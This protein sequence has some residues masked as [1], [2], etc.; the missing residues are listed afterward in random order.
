MNLSAISKLCTAIAVLIFANLA[1]T[2]NDTIKNN[3]R[4][5]M[6]LSGN[7]SLKSILALQGNI[8][9]V[10][11]DKEL[12]NAKYG[13]CVYSLT[14]KKSIYQKSSKSLLTPASN[15]KLF[16]SFAALNYLGEHFNLRSSAYCNRDAIKDG[17]L[18]GN[19]YIYGRGDI[20][21]STADIEDLAQQIKNYGIKKIKGHVCADESF[22]DKDYYRRSYSGD[23]EEVEPTG[24]IYPLTVEKNLIN[25]LVKASARTGVAAN[26][27]IIPSSSSFVVRNLTRVGNLGK[28]NP[29][30]ST[31]K[32]SIKTESNKTYITV[33]GVISPNKTGYY[34]YFNTLP[35]ITVA[36]VLKDRLGVVGVN[37]D[38][39]VSV[40]SYG[41]IHDE[42]AVE[43]ANIERP[44]TDI[45]YL[46]NKKSDNFLAEMMFKIVGGNY[47]KYPNTAQSAREKVK[48][49][50][51]ENSIEYKGF[52]LND[53][54]GLSR[55]NLVT[56][57][58]LLK[59]LITAKY[60]SY[61]S[62]LDSTLAIAG[63]DGTLRKRMIGTRAENNLRAKT[64]T[65]R[66]A[67]ALSGYV[68]AQS[69]ELLAFSFIF[70]GPS[71]GY[72]KQK[73]NMIGVLLAD[74]NYT[75]H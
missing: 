42:N 69:G 57:D 24:P 36:G 52:Q 39:T 50:L 55:R 47:G 40:A 23:N 74:F 32:V 10:L 43:V 58:A 64:G 34:S 1:V 19:I 54:C 46:V 27:Q 4:V 11:N 31:I 49:V 26:V 18:D 22:F 29:N 71:V 70:N 75:K 33:S 15:T 25:V 53:G 67:S 56:P 38:G 37:V 41:N 59:L 68:R 45:M 3:A 20:N 5:D 73:E 35:A 30:G 51:G 9:A 7:D 63:V 8:N 6:R 21:L 48:Q 65:L 28:K 12:R 66:N 60:K 62:I 2:S 61:G 16:T 17:V 14:S 44:L 13:L 72:Y